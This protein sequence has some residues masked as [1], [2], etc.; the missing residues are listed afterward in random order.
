MLESLY[1]QVIREH[2]LSKENKHPLPE[3]AF[4]VSGSNPSC[5]DEVELFLR[6]ADG[7]IQDASYTGNGCAISQASIS[8][9]IDL[10]RGK[11]L[12]EAEKLTQTFLRMI[13][14]ETLTERE[15][16]ALEDA[17]A[18]E[19]ISAMPARVKCATMP[20]H[21]LEKAIARARQSGAGVT[22]I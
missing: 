11:T 3:P 16:D 19:G 8:M 7:L 17:V 15:K 21:T 2:N 6:V 20:W 12:R 22:S 10:V 1:S 13:R 4:M 14:R 5:G 9:M 18:L